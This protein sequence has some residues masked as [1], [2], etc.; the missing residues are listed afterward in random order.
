MEVER[1]VQLAYPRENHPLIDNHKVEVFVYDI[2]GPEIKLA[3][4][5][6]ETVPFSLAQ[7][8]AWTICRPQMDEV[9]KVEAVEE[10]ECLLNNLEEIVKQVLRENGQILNLNALT[11]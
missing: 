2:R 10:K 9:Q 5:I 1:L 11:V 6:P 4:N 7:V 8:T 3:R